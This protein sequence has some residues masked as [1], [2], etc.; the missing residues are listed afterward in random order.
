MQTTVHHLSIKFNIK[1]ERKTANLQS[2]ESRTRKSWKHF[3]KKQLYK[4]QLLV[5][6]SSQVVT[7]RWTVTDIVL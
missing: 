3:A 1:S 4:D 7:S 2:L 5:C 6:F